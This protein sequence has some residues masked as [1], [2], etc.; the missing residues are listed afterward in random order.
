MVNLAKIDGNFLANVSKVDGTEKGSISKIDGLLLE[1]PLE[2]GYATKQTSVSCPSSMWLPY[3]ESGQLKIHCFDT[4]VVIGQVAFTSVPTKW[5]RDQYIK[6]HQAG[7]N[8]AGDLFIYD[9]STLTLFTVGTVANNQCSVSETGE[10]VAAGKH[11]AVGNNWCFWIIPSPYQSTITA[12]EYNHHNDYPLISVA[13]NN[14]WVFLFFQSGATVNGVALL[15]ST[16]VLETPTIHKQTFSGPGSRFV[17]LP[18]RWTT[19]YCYLHSND[20]YDPSRTWTW[21]VPLN[22]ICT[23]YNHHL[24]AYGALSR[25][26]S[27]HNGTKAVDYIFQPRTTYD[28][29]FLIQEHDCAVNIQ[30]VG[31]RWHVK[32]STDFYNDG[33]VLINGSSVNWA[34]RKWTVN[35]GLSLIRTRTFPWL[36]YGLYGRWAYHTSCDCAGTRVAQICTLQQGSPAYMTDTIHITNNIDTEDPIYKLMLTYP[37]FRISWSSLKVGFS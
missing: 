37:N 3:Y 25:C 35:T 5:A 26:Q 30:T 32:V 10:I 36:G 33:I 9:S 2:C 34:G 11:P 20:G 19:D 28:E 8:N 12:Y 4:D 1:E 18:P 31:S 29:R 17:I 6:T 27:F 21:D 13:S 7:I 16:L 24:G 14:E 15:K 22:S 23:Y